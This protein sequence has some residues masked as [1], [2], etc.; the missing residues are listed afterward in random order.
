MRVFDGR[1]IAAARALSNMSVRDLA[2]AAGV[3]ARTIGRLEVDMAITI[4]PKLRHGHVSRATFDKIVAALTEHGVEL[5]PEDE[6]YGSGVR[7]KKPR[8]ER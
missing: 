7:W 5:L 3:T 6:D 1:Q 8:G 4:A 2:Q